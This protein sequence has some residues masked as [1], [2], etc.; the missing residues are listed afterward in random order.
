MSEQDEFV[1]KFRRNVTA[2]MIIENQRL[3]GHAY[4]LALVIAVLDEDGWSYVVQLLNAFDTVD[5]AETQMTKSA[6]LAYKREKK[7]FRGW[8]SE[9][10]KHGWTGCGKSA[11][12]LPV[13]SNSS[14]RIGDG[15]HFNSRGQW[16]SVLDIRGVTNPAEAI[17]AHFEGQFAVREYFARLGEEARGAPSQSSPTS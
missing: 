16:F 2:G 7:A 10:E 8:V 3:A 5:D 9:G 6:Q 1:E 13:V 15:T 11:G 17:S 12:A 14:F 4:V